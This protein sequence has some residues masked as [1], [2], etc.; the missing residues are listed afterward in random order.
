MGNRWCCVAQFS[1]VTRDRVVL[2]D[3]LAGRG[4]SMADLVLVLAFGNFVLDCEEI[5]GRWCCVRRK[6]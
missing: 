6:A 1:G 4:L 3:G 5:R 2:C